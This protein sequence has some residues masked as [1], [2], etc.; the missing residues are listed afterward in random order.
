[1]ESWQPTYPA[2]SAELLR[3]D[4]SSTAMAENSCSC[5]VLRPAKRQ[6]VSWSKSSSG[7]VELPDASI[8]SWAALF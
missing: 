2:A 1:M 8:P 4:R 3:H 5:S 7:A 6:Q